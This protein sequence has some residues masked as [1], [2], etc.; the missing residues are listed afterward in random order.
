MSSSRTSLTVTMLVLAIIGAGVT[1]YLTI[2]HGRGAA[3]LCVVGHGCEVIAQSSFA[4]IGRLP[5]AA[6]GL[7]G[8]LLL[9]GSFAMRLMHPP[10]EIDRLLIRATLG[11]ALF[12]FGV[13]AFL[14]GVAEFHLHATCI[15][16]L[17]SAVDMTILAILTS[18]VFFADWRVPKVTADDDV[19]DDPR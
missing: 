16:C 15:W 1:T 6:I 9:A 18:Y 12:G 13:S 5:S 3:P 8:Y 11:M 14:I 19:D 10:E 17:S 7:L 2:E 4:H